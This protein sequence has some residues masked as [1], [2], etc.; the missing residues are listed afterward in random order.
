MFW[1]PKP[2]KGKRRSPDSN[3]IVSNCNL[4]PSFQAEPGHSSLGDQVSSAHHT[5]RAQFVQTQTP[6]WGSCHPP[7]MPAL[8]SKS[9]FPV[10]VINMARANDV[11]SWGMGTS[12]KHGLDQVVRDYLVSLLP[13]E[14]S[15]AGICAGFLVVR[16]S[17]L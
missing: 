6:L 2:S 3:Q 9:H 13:L 15:P 1:E 17:G 4:L 16:G 14:L 10:L 11:R 5:D 12:P 8:E 7:A